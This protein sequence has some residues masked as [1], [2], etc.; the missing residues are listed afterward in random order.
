M[1]LGV[2][3]H[4]RC[5]GMVPGAWYLSSDCIMVGSGAQQAG[6][7][8][9]CFW[10]SKG[11]HV[12]EESRGPKYTHYPFSSVRGQG[13]GPSSLFGKSCQAPSSPLFK[14]VPPAALASASTGNFPLPRSSPTACWLERDYFPGL[15]GERA[16]LLLGSESKLLTAAVGGTEEE[17]G[18]QEGLLEPSRYRNSPISSVSS[19]QDWQL[20]GH[21]YPE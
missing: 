20:Q 17:A 5:T 4:I 7:T 11:R 2:V 18:L 1:T 16:T 14:S 15:W 12:P 19:E 13:M 6:G 9:A 3:Q 8:K 10:V 21:T